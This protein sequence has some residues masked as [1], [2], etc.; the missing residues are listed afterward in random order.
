M[1]RYAN[2]ISWILLLPAISFMPGAKKPAPL[3]AKWVISKGCS[4][5]VNG[6]TNV[7]TFCCGIT[8]YCNPDTIVVYKNPD[9]ELVL[10][11]TGQLNLN[12]TGFDCHNVFMTKDLRKTLKAG[13]FPI[14]SIRF[15]S[16]SKLPDFRL[17]GDVITGL[18]DIDLAGVTK[19]F[20]MSYKFSMDDQKVIHLAGSRIINFS[21]FNLVPP[22][23][24]GGMIRTNDRLNVGF[25][26][27]LKTIN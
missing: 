20:E 16:L 22:R 14:M 2:L 15:L 8:D 26:L 18:V 6:S 12:V 24:L 27:N 9:K 21:D 1:S 23:K 19:R 25:H 4:L 7:N 11:V 5:Q 10:P 17:P 13:D 3:L